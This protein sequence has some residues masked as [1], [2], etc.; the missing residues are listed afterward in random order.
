MLTMCHET[1]ERCK[2]EIAVHLAEA[3]NRKDHLRKV[4]EAQ[5]KLDDLGRDA[6]INFASCRTLKSCISYQEQ[7]NAI[8]VEGYPGGRWPEQ[9]EP[10]P[11]IYRGI[12]GMYRDL[13]FAIGLEFVIKGTL[14][15]LDKTDPNWV[16]DLH[17]LVK[18][19]LFMAQA[20]DND[21]NWLAAEDKNLMSREDMRNVARG[22]I[23][24]LCV[25]AKFTF[26]SDTNFVRALYNWAGYSLDNSYDLKITSKKFREGFEKSQNQLLK[27]ANMSAD[28]ALVLPSEKEVAKLKEETQ[29]LRNA[30]ELGKSLGDVKLDSESGNAAP[31]EKLGKNMGEKMVEKVG[32]E[33]ENVE[34][35]AAVAAAEDGS[36]K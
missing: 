17:D 2:K 19:I 25:L 11:T 32:K 22:Y 12:G 20:G 9:M 27:W 30:E 33:K 21:I 4:K 29:A 6:Q 13:A 3:P 14:Y 36:H 28:H 35:V 1:G 8:V 24:I 7:V 18:F 15:V 34:P 10:L 23:A 5:M 26:G 16:G 31:D